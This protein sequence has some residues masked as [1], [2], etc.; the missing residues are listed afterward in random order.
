MHNCSAMGKVLILS[1]IGVVGFLKSSV[2]QVQNFEAPFVI[3]NHPNEFLPGWTG[4]DVRS[5]ATRIFQAAGEGIGNSRALAVQPLSTYTGIFQVTLPIGEYAAPK[6]AFF[7]KSRQNGTGNRPALLFVSFSRDGGS[8]FQ[9]LTPIGD[10]RTFPNSN[11]SYMPFEIPIPANLLTEEQIVARFEVRFG[12]GTGTAARFFMDN[13]ALLEA[14]ALIDPI[15]IKQALQFNPFTIHLAFDREIE[16]LEKGQVSSTSGRQVR[17]LDM[18]TDSTLLIQFNADLPENFLITLNGVKAKD[19]SPSQNIIQ[20]FSNSELKLGEVRIIDPEKMMLSFNRNIPQATASQTASYRVNGLPPR[21]V[22][23]EETGYEVLLELAAPLILNQVVNLTLSGLDGLLG[24][25][26]RSLMFDDFIEDVYLPNA[27]TLKLKHKVA[28]LNAHLDTLSFLITDRADIQLKVT[29][30]NDDGLVILTSNLP[31]EENT[32]HELVVPYRWSTRG[33]F[34]PGS[35]REVVYDTTAPLILEI[36]PL[37]NRQLMLVFSELVDPLFANLPG[38]YALNGI[39]PLTATVQQQGQQVLLEWQQAFASAANQELTVQGIPDLTGNFMLPQVVSVVFGSIG[40]LDFKSIVINE[41]MAAPRANQTLPNVEYLELYNSTDRS[42]S[43]SG[44]VVANSRRSTTLPPAIL[45]A[46]GYVLLVPRNQAAQFSRFGHTLGLSSWPALLNAADHITLRD[47]S[48]KLID[49]LRYTTASY[50]SSALAQGGYSLEIVN[51][52]NK[53]QEPSNLKPSTAAQRGTPGARNSVF[54]QGSFSEAF[55]FVRAQVIDGRQVVLLFNKT[56][57]PD[58]NLDQIA[59]EPNLRVVRARIGP[60]PNQLTLELGEEIRQGIKYKVALGQFRECGGKLI[61]GR[62]PFFV[63]PSKAEPGDIVINEVLFNPLSG[64]PKFVEIYNTSDKF[65]NLRDWKLANLNSSGEIA[66][67]RNM[68]AEDFLIEPYS[69][70]VFTTDANKLRQDYPRAVQQN[71]IELSSLPSYPITAGNVV[72]LNPD[73][74]LTELFGYSERMH[75]RLLKEVKG[76][77]LERISP[78]HPVNELSNWQSAS[79]SAGFATPGFR[80]SHYASGPL[81]DGIQIEPKVFFP[82]DVGDISFTRISYQLGQPGKIGSIRIYGLNGHEIR[83]ICQ[84]ALWGSE[85]FY[86]WDGTDN[87]GRKVRPG[88]YVVWVQVFDLQGNIAETR[89]TV[90]V[91]TKF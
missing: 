86:L 77:S 12:L 51:P 50:G 7:A 5:T 58:V 4:N 53:C 70:L 73:E 21:A 26:S 33:L 91:G 65:I 28:L 69:F 10:E 79:S 3:A 66:N 29:S 16:P 14:D 83:E 85:G 17:H 63:R 31:L 22:V 45:P 11:Q 60:L 56:I 47:I 78:Q 87:S 25:E 55:T 34:L 75:H 13:F 19:G 64:S 42:V 62:E 15:A 40:T 30:N 1:I 24:E 2:G 6:M 9:Q 46:G 27:Q 35:R 54:D 84:N 38:L 68:F 72:L 49:S 88:Y 8:S 18:P 67:R 61:E 52:Y 48:G 59:V 41:V 57:K 37:S 36:I 80:N 39:Q 20:A 71:L 32:V 82:E 74:S 90:V 89:K 43:I 81:A 44:L 76:V 23:L